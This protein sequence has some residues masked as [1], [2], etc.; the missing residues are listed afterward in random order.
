MTLLHRLASIVRWIVRR[1][2][3]E[4]NLNDELQAFIDMAAD[5]EVRDGATA[6]EARVEPRSSWEAW[7]RPRHAFEVLAMARGSM[8][9]GETSAMDC[10]RSDAIRRSR[11]S[12]SRR[13]LSASAGLRR[14]SAPST[15]C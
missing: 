5:D 3:A 9:P 2:R 15:R 13:S 7:N 1:E 8:W 14:C 10:G 4:Q 6:P 11:L 12:R